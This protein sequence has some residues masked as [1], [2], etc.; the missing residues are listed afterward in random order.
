MNDD[1]SS[2]SA[3]LPQQPARKPWTTPVVS[4]LSMDRTENG[5]RGGNDGGG[6]FTG[7]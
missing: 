3:E 2:I 5:T 6:T 4:F 1:A 7:S